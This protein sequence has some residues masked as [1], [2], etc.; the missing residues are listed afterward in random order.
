MAQRAYSPR[1]IL[2]IKVPR[3]DETAPEWVALLGRQR[4]RGVWFVWGNSGNGKTE[5]VMQLLRMFARHGRTHYLSLEE[6]SDNDHMQEAIRRNRLDE[7]DNIR[8]SYDTYDELCERLR[9]HKSPRFVI[10]ETLQYWDISY[11]QYKAL[12]EEFRHCLFVFVSHVSEDGRQPDGAVARRIKRDSDLRLW[13]EGF[14]VFNR[15]RTMGLT[16]EYTIW[17]DGAS[18]YWAVA[19]E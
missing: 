2:K 17:P 8:I 3:L 16:N 12:K 7:M 4:S 18:R 11:E 1:E 19:K 15:G 9:A 14:K 6:A 5:F 10:V 13:L